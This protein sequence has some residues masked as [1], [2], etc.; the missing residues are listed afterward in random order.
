LSWQRL[1]FSPGFSY[2]G[3]GWVL[4]WVYVLVLAEAEILTWVFLS[5][6]RMG[7]HLGICTCPGRG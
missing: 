6:Q 4:N 3:R 2:P 7:S 5:W 1:R